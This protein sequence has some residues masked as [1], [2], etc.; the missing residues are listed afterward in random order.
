MGARPTLCLAF[1]IDFPVIITQIM[2]SIY[3]YSPDLS[4]PLITKGCPAKKIWKL[5]SRL[6]RLERHQPKSKVMGME[7]FTYMDA[8]GD[9][10]DQL[11]A[12]GV[13][14]EGLYEQY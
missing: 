4:S 10:F 3:C 8:I 1:S 11:E 9:T 6:T 2:Y 5:R 14:M 13:P 12:L 7:C